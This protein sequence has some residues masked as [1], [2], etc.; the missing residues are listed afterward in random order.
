MWNAE[1]QTDFIGSESWHSKI[2]ADLT[3]FY[4]RTANK[5]HS[6]GCIAFNLFFIKGVKMKSI[7]VLKLPAVMMVSVLFLL[8]AQMAR[9]S[10]LFQI[11]GTVN[12]EAQFVADN[13][14]IYEIAETAR[15]DALTDEVGV[16]VEVEGSIEEHDGVLVIRV[17]DFRVLKESY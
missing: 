15:G 17:I 4:Q 8:A 10:D 16:P 13:G 2:A 7:V 11:R 3:C 14:E 5:V 1:M 9:S 6:A 12:Q